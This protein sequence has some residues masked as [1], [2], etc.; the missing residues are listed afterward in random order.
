[1]K[2]RPYLILPR[3]GSTYEFEKFQ[4][5]P[6]Y[7]GEIIYIRDSLYPCFRI[8]LPHEKWSMPYYLAEDAHAALEELCQPHDKAL[9]ENWVEKHRTHFN[10]EA[11]KLA[12]LDTKKPSLLRRLIDWIDGL[13]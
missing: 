10:V 4:P 9:V 11:H 8:G 12:S 13:L 3:R 7:V 6:R 5:K 1:M 2:K